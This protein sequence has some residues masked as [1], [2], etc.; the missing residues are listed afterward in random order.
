MDNKAGC[1]HILVICNNSILSK[2]G[3]TGRRYISLI[4]EFQL[5]GWQVLLVTLE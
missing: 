4:L 3:S 1:N 5:E 2:L